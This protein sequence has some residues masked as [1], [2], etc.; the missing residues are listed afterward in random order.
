MY[1]SLEPKRK[2][3]NLYNREKELNELKKATENGRI[4]LLTGIRRIGKTSLL[5][6]FLEERKTLGD[7]YVFLDCRSFVRNSRRINRSDFDL[8]F[9]KSLEKA[10]ENKK[11]RNILKTV[12]ISK[13]SISGIQV[14]LQKSRSKPL[15]VFQRLNNADQALK[16]VGKKLIIAL[17]EAQN[18]RFYGVGG[19][20]MLN[21]FAHTYDHL[22]NVKF[23]ITGSEVGLLHD[24]LKLDDPKA[25]MYGRYVNE[26]SLERFTR[27]ESIN[28][29]IKGFKQVHI[30]PNKEE[31][32][33]AVNMLD[34]MVGYLVIYG[35][36]VYFK[37]DYKNALRD[38]TKMAEGLI[39]LE[40]EELNKRSENYKNV[41]KAV[42]FGMENF[43]N[44]RKYIK[45]NYGDITDQT[46]SNN[47]NS[48]V[49]QCFLKYQYKDGSKVYAIPDPILRKVILSL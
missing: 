7:V 49:K 10:I 35:Y 39:K 41:L 22:Q 25:P 44:I 47:I 40:I 33:K 1:F 23:I 38:A 14:D 30:E 20:P 37:K 36:V 4:I 45:L 11:L 32:E 29:L 48:L 9:S 18:L 42:A 17:D 2:R 8:A 27:K 34:G 43:S 16:K 24:F 12:S 31:I 26:I 3:E 15:D 21:L 13:I 5:Q 28:F 19:Y 46:L 6:V